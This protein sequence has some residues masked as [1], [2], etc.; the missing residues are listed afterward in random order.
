MQEVVPLAALVAA[1]FLQAVPPLLA[2]FD[3]P[4][5]SHHEEHRE[6]DAREILEDDGDV[7][8]RRRVEVG[9]AVVVDGEAA[10]GGGG[11]GVVDGTEAVHACQRIADAAADGE[12]DVYPPDAH[13]GRA[14]PRMHLGADGASGF[15][16]EHL[17]R[18][19]HH[20]GKDGDGE[21]DD[22]Q[23]SDPLRERPPEEHGLMVLELCLDVVEHRGSRGG[24]PGH[25]L[26]ERV[27]GDIPHGGGAQEA[28]VSEEATE[29][30]GQRP[31][32][33][34]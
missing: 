23:T 10:G 19:A 34:E 26:E 5:D 11:H 6:I 22:S 4:H 3:A 9:D 13:G 20:R 17:H 7:F 30:I 1:E 16:R 33:T 24:E 32:D 31:E 8:Y 21:E 18:V 29:E 25:G 27:G 2:P 15:G 14:E 12:H 28:D